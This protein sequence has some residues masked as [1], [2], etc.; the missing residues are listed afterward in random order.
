MTKE[1][2][3]YFKMKLTTKQQQQDN[4]ELLFNTVKTLSESQRSYGRLLEQL[5]SMSKDER[6]ELASKLPNFKDC[7]D[8]ILWIEQ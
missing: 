2:G 1:F 4:Y 5:N 6:L 8:V 7:V 3:R